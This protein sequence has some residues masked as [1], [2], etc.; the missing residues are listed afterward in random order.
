M[1]VTLLYDITKGSIFKK[2]GTRYCCCTEQYQAENYYGLQAA[3][4]WSCET[5]KHGDFLF[6]CMYCSTFF[7]TAPSTASVS[8]DADIEPRTVSTFALAVRGSNRLAKS[9]PLSDKSHPLSAK[10]QPLSD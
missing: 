7:N 6:V 9:H 4:Y 10:S 5:F 1:Y 3:Q 8:E 2:K